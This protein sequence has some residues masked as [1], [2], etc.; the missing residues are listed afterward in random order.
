MNEK[1]NQ[2]MP[3]ASLT[4]GIVALLAVLFYYISLPSSIMAII[5]GIKARINTGSKLGLAGMI[6]GIVAL[7]IMLVLY[8]G[9]LALIVLSHY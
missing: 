4:L 8:L 5:F 3:T 2:V 6:L 1:N 7:S 9:M